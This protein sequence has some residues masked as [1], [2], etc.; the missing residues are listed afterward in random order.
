MYW[1]N[2]STL[3]RDKRSASKKLRRTKGGMDGKNISRGLFVLNKTRN[4]ASSATCAGKWCAW[5]QCPS[6]TPST[7]SGGSSTSLTMCSA[8]SL[9]AGLWKVMTHHLGHYSYFLGAPCK[10]LSKTFEF[11]FLPY[12]IK[13]L[14]EELKHLTNFLLMQISPINNKFYF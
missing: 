14:V 8:I 13:L 2:T 12:I 1:P 11:N 3:R 5:P 9:T 6:T 10:L 4:R 7:R